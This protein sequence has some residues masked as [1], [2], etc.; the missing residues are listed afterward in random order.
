[1]AAR[2]IDA[3][4][5][6][7][8]GNPAAGGAGAAVAAIVSAVT[9]AIW[10]VNPY[11]AALLLPAAHLWLFLCAP[12]TRL[13]GALAWI[14]LAAGLLGPLAVAFYEMRALDVGPVALARMWLVATAGGHVSAWAAVAV[15]ALAGSL[16]LL[17]RV[18][19]ARGTARAR[20]ARGPA[21]HPRPGDLRRA[22]A[23]SAARSPPCG[24][25]RR[26]RHPERMRRVLRALSAVLIVAGV[27]LLA[28]GALT[29]LWKEPVSSL[30]ARIEQ[31]RLDDE[32]DAARA[33]RS[34]RRSSGACS[35]QL[36]DPRRRLSFAARALGGGR[37]TATRSGACGSPRIGLARVVVE[38]TGSLGPAQGPGALPGNAAAG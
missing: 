25:D 26:V 15:G 17:V 21:S 6:G 22:R 38:G 32:L 13:R 37:P 11:A 16:L 20:G 35:P 10:I 18:I 30:Y 7:R 19:L 29:L 4:D 34:R 36:P 31:G 33:R 1:M 9:L 28:D 3:A 8:R 27:L 5:A 14:A 12:E 24:A 2:M 23:R